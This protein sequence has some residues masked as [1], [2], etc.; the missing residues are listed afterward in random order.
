VHA[1]LAD[2]LVPDLDLIT[3]WP[4]LDHYAGQRA[5][6]TARFIGPERIR[7]PAPQVRWP[8]TANPKVLAYLSQGCTAL[9]PLL[10]S[11]AQS[12]A[13]TVAHVG[14]AAVASILPPWAGNM[15]L[16]PDLFDPGPTLN[17]CDVLVC[18]AA[19]GMTGA[20]LAAGKPVLMWPMTAEQQL[21]A[22]RVA[23]LGVGANLPQE[24]TPQALSGLLQRAI[25]PMGMSGRARA[26][27]ALHAH[28]PD[29]LARGVEAILDWL[30]A[31]PAA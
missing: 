16:H 7:T 10:H 24:P 31:G 3:C 17:A 21:F 27:A 20:A 8:G 29:G 18:H 5:P 1:S 4:E 23:E 11:L 6:G 12:G 14:E 13:A 25:D 22:H 28:E 15:V 2:A 19:N 9:N 30:P 26:L